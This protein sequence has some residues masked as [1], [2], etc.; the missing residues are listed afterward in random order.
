M[1]DITQNLE[2]ICYEYKMVIS[3][4]G[5]FNQGLNHCVLKIKNKFI[6]YSS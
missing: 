2:R 5:I 4:K 3:P 6:L 1:L